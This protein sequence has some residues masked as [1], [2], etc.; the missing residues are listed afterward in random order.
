VWYLAEERPD[1]C[2]SRFPIAIVALLTGARM[3]VTPAVAA[4]SRGTAGRTWSSRRTPRPGRPVMSRTSSGSPPASSGS[5]PA[6]PQWPRVGG[7]LPAMPDM[8]LKINGPD[9]S[10]LVGPFGPGDCHCPLPSSTVSPLVPQRSVMS[11]STARLPGSGDTTRHRR[12]RRAGLRAALLAAA[13]I[14]PLTA[15]FAAATPAQAAQPGVTQIS[16]DPYSPDSAPAAAHA[17]EVEP[18]TFAHGSTVVT[19]FQVGRVFN[20]G[21]SN[22]GWA[23]SRDGGVSW[24][25]GFLPATTTASTPTGPFFAASDPSV[26]YDARDRVWIIS[27]LGAHFS[28]GGIV[29]VMV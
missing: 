11:I 5:P 15:V 3:A 28:G 12:A 10:L 25:H 18:D 24:T 20:G 1:M 13:L 8:D 19:A 26:A 6:P 9:T 14:T 29:D 17:T 2:R 23:T 27:W 21:A 22:I 4:G 16:S 7:G